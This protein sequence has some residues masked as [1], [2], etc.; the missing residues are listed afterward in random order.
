MLARNVNFTLLSF[1][2]FFATVLILYYYLLYVDLQTCIISVN[3]II[4]GGC[5]SE[6]LDM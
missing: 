3:K 1:L 6:S 4:N 2:T 5:L